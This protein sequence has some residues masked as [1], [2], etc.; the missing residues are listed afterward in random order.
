MYKLYGLSK[1][2]PWRVC[3]QAGV[4]GCLYKDALAN[5]LLFS[6]YFVQSADR[7]D[8]MQR[9]PGTSCFDL[10]DRA[11]EYP[12]LQGRLV[13]LPSAD[14]AAVQNNN[15]EYNLADK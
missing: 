2:Y 5:V 14:A 13:W 11:W 3:L 8:V 9:V 15:N 1:L 12:M 6:T 10:Q 7:H 4:I